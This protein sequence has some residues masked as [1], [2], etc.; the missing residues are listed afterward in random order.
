MIARRLI[1]LAAY[2]AVVASAEVASRAAPADA[3]APRI[4]PQEYVALL[5]RVERSIVDESGTSTSAS[6]ELPDTL[7]LDTDHG[8]FD[9]PTGDLRRELRLSRSRRDEASRQ[10]LLRSIAALRADVSEFLATPPDRSAERAL[11]SRVLARPEF[12]YV[13]GPTWRERLQQRV[14]RLLE[15]VLGRIPW[16]SIPNVSDPIVFGLVIASLAVAVLWAMRLFRRSSRAELLITPPARTAPRQW[17]NWLADA[18]AA[19]GEGR[20]RD[21][22]HLCY[23]SGIAFLE[24]QGTWRPDRSRTPREYVALVSA[25]TEIR[26]ALADMTRRLESVWYGAEIADANTFAESRRNLEKLGCPTS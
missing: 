3:I 25:G 15:R 20:W 10:R 6:N 13:H 26:S 18:N 9:I 21:A 2:A 1:T 4:S 19:A 11:L 14:L 7:R 17:Q 5:D 8:S 23:W 22:V 12:Q 24:Q 16:S